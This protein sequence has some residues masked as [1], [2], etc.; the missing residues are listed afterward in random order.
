MV[1]GKWLTAQM[2]ACYINKNHPLSDSS[3]VDYVMLHHSMSYDTTLR[4]LYLNGKVNDEGVYHHFVTGN[5]MSTIHCYQVCQKGETWNYH[6][7][8]TVCFWY[9]CLY[10]TF[11]HNL[12]LEV[13]F[14]IIDDE[15]YT[16]DDRNQNTNIKEGGS[17]GDCQVAEPDVEAV[18]IPGDDELQVFLS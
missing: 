17:Y 10:N 6:K 8:N 2:W 7:L 3:L 16:K 14:E 13:Q 18:D 15:S 1:W 4:N 11:T 5:N 9:K 12:R